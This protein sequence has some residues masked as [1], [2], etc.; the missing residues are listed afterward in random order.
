LKNPIDRF[1]NQTA[2]VICNYTLLTPPSSH[3][4]FYERSCEKDVENKPCRF[5]DRKMFNHSRCVQKFTYTYA[6]VR[7]ISGEHTRHQKHFPALPGAGWAMD[8]IKIRSGCS[9]ELRPNP[10][11]HRRPTGDRKR[12]HGHRER[13]KDRTT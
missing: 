13:K 6:L 1:Y 7:D 10:R 9:C 4:R 2:F 5:I 3:S 8:Y 11:R 12:N